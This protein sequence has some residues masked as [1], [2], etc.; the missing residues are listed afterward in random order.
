MT[1]PWHKPAGC[2]DEPAALW[3]VLAQYANAAKLTAGEKQ[4]DRSMATVRRF[5]WHAGASRPGHIT[6]AT[7]TAYLAAR[8]GEGLSRKTLLNHLSSIRSFARYL[9]SR[10]RLARD[11]CADVHVGPVEEKLPRYLDDAELAVVLRVARRAGIWPEVSLALA[12]GLRLGELVRLGWADVDRR[13]R[14]LTVRKSKSRRPR[15]VPLSRLALQALAE[16]A[17]KSGGMGQVFPARRTWRGGWAY[18]D[19]PRESSCWIRAL[20]PIKA[21]VPKFA[22]APGKCTGRG[23][24]LFRHTFASRAVQ[25]GVSLYK[26]AQWLG[27]RDVRTTQIYAHL[28]VGFDPDIE[29]AAPPGTAVTG[30]GD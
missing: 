11:P 29:E 15:V 17:K 7:V 1:A 6:E 30:E 28:A 23:W 13:R 3:A 21:A 22:A 20:K 12:T 26:V 2:A 9:V 19:K 5:L 24:H 16:Q 10:G 18:V 25:R 14:C 4:V 8:S 27:H